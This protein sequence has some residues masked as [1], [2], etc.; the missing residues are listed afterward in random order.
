ML[1]M[2]SVYDDDGVSTQEK[3]YH[4]SCLKCA[5]CL[6]NVASKAFYVHEGKAYC[7]QD[8]IALVYPGCHVCTLPVT[9]EVIEALGNSFHP[10]CFVCVKCS[11]SLG[12]VKFLVKDG[13]LFC[14]NDFNQIYGVTCDACK[15]SFVL[16]GQPQEC[17]KVG[18]KTF[19]PQC[20]CCTVLFYFPLNLFFFF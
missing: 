12:G 7:E 13:K 11:K 18:D 5:T 19:H 3:Q 6:M 17:L 16:D 9:Q 10:E 15:Q 2:R 14:E 8:Y 20:F 4:K 1:C